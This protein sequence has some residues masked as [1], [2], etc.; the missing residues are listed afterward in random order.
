MTVNG[1]LYS[2]VYLN[3]ELLMKAY[4]NWRCSAVRPMSIIAPFTPYSHGRLNDWMELDYVMRRYAE[5]Q[6]RHSKET[7]AT[8]LNKCI[9][10]HPKCRDARQSDRLKPT[11]LLYLDPDQTDIVKLV[12]VTDKDD[13]QYVT[14]SHRW[15]SPEPPKLSKLYNDS[16]QGREI[17]FGVL[18][19]GKRISELP[20]LFKDAIHI[21]RCC[22]LKYLWIDS[23]CICQDKDPTNRNLEWEK[24]SEKMADIYAGGVFNIAATHGQNSEAGL[25]PIQRDILLPVVPDMGIGGQAQ[26]LWEVPDSRFKHDIIESKLLSRGWVYQ[27]VLLTPANLFCTT[28]EMWWS[29]SHTTCSE[30]FPEGVQELFWTMHSKTREPQPFRDSLGRRRESIMPRD[31]PDP[32]KAWINVL[33]FYPQTSVTVSSDRLVAI[34]GIANLFKALFPNQLQNAIYHSGVWFSS[35]IPR[36]L[37]QLLWSRWKFRQLPLHTY[38]ATYPMPSWS[39]ANIKEDLSFDI[40]RRTI[41][42]PVEFSGLIDVREDNLDKFRPAVGHARCVLHL[43]GVLL[44]VDI[45]HIGVDKPPFIGR[46]SVSGIKESP[47]F[48]ITWDSVYM[49]DKWTDARALIFTLSRHAVH[50][51]GLLLKPV[52]RLPD[53]EGRV[54]WERCGYLKWYNGTELGPRKAWESLELVRYGITYNAYQGLERDTSA[55]LDLEDI[56][57]V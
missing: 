12:L 6:P 56:Y 55:Q 22:G 14:L 42:A 43:R 47:E 4:L 25:F 52:N 33:T 51:E 34:A 35:D 8:W 30:S 53:S 11:R 19:K 21:V 54:V 36:Y 50:G 16:D 37:H 1:L 27:E 20:Q 2:T 41:L 26:L 40:Y 28:D 18:E 7:V 5:P 45:T 44:R 23:L 10:D 24:E 3:P 31:T 57:I 13:Y 39:P 46:A 29:C 38:A 48:E 32:M 17:S 49:A 9:K 15:G